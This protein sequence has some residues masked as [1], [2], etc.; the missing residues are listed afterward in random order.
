MVEYAH[1]EEN[2]IIVSDMIDMGLK[3]KYRGMPLLLPES[4][5]TPDIVKC[6]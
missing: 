4:F 6:H 3:G 1:N 5:E 2:T